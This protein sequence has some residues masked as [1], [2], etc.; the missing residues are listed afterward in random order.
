MQ[1]KGIQELFDEECIEKIYL[2]AFKRTQNSHDAEDLAQDILFQ[3]L[4]SIDKGVKP[5]RFHAWIWNIARKRWYKFLEQRNKSGSKTIHME[6]GQVMP[7]ADKSESD[8]E[9]YYINSEEAVELSRAISRLSS[10][11]REIIILYYL[12]EK[13]IPEIA[14]LLSIPE[15]TVKSRLYDARQKIKRRMD[16]M[17]ENSRKSYAPAE[18]NLWGAYEAPKFWNELFRSLTKNIFAAAYEEPVTLEELSDELGV[19]RVYIE[20]EIERLVEWGFIKKH[21]TDQYLTNFIMLDAQKMLDF[22]I[23]A[24]DTWNG[25]AERMIRTLDNVKD[26]IL[27]LDF[28][29][30]QFNWNYLLWIFIVFACTSFS[31]IALKNYRRKWQDKNMPKYDKDYRMMGIVKRA[32]QELIFDPAD[33]KYVSWSNLHQYFR[34]IG[35]YREVVYAN[36]YQCEPFSN[37]DALFNDFGIRLLIR[38]SKNHDA[39]SLT[40]YEKESAA[41]LIEKG[42]VKNDSG[43]LIPQI[44]M[45]ESHTLITIQELISK[46][47]EGCVDDA[48]V[49][50]SELADKI[51]LPLVRKNL[52]EQYVNWVMLVCLDPLPYVLY[53]CKKE[54]FLQEPRDFSRAPH[55]IYLRLNKKRCNRGRFFVADDCYRTVPCLILLFN[56]RL[57]QVWIL[58]SGRTQI[59]E[60]KTM[61]NYADAKLLRY[62]ER[63]EYA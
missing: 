5:E 41:Y 11:H 52:L 47:I 26:D 60:R 38:L 63:R 58:S 16:Q 36:L 54:G 35:E 29:G 7:L 21:G 31:D 33:I 17:K 48:A 24:A 62:N 4:R 50:V 9:E 49:K 14:K 10:L 43:A 28:Y 34:N 53:Q 37:R 8:P 23:K 51:L 55:A 13:S 20:E 32:D 6:G 2:F 12:Q 3:A 61:K 1:N 39:D 30:N 57:K 19:A 59:Q 40:T 45:I 18:V 46:A 25:L 22:K 27:A 44:P 42:I 56:R 15:G